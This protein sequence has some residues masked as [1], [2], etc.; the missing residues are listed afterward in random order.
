MVYGEVADGAVYVRRALALNSNLAWAWVVSGLA[1]ALLGRGDAAAEHAD[2]AMRL[3]T[4]DPHSFGMLFVAALGDFLA[5]R[6]DEACEK[7]MAALRERPN[8]AS[9]AGVHAAGAA[10][11][12][13]LDAA[14]R[15]MANLREAMPDLR[16]STPAAWLPFQDAGAFA[17]W[18]EGLRRAGLPE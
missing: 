10:M 11:S 7:A 15:A 2:R 18:A 3:S 9:A 5:G 8:F 13:R 4:Q 16:I 1:E 14:R 17:R 6:N 12:G